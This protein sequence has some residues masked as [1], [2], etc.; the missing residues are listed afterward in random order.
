MPLLILTVIAVL[1]LVPDSKDAQSLLADIISEAKLA[2][3]IVVEMLEFVRPVR[4]Q[5]EH[6]NIADVLHQAFIA[7][8]DEGTE[9]VVFGFEPV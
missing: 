3:A 5:V 4:L 8:D 6:T 1:A 9:A 2:N 7:V